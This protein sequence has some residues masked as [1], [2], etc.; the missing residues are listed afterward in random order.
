LKI[1]SGWRG[2][3]REEEEYLTFE[4]EYRSWLSCDGNENGIIIN[5]FE[6]KEEG[7]EGF[8]TE[9]WNKKKKKNQ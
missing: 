5:G 9:K 6:R 1:Q 7:E 8:E 3:T 2:W 4:I